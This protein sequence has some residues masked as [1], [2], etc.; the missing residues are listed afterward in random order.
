MVIA[1]SALRIEQAHAA[2][3]KSVNRK[4]IQQ[5]RTEH[6]QLLIW[7]KEQAQAA[8]DEHGRTTLEWWSGVEWSGPFSHFLPCQMYVCV[9][10]RECV[11]VQFDV[12]DI[13]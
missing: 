3:L 7:Q 4:I 10:A 8:K 9:R 1:V 5:S 2:R 13:W 6:A 12:H 11:P